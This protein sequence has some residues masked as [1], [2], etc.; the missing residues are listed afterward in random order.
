M[1]VI[2]PSDHIIEDGVH[3]LAEQVLVIV[4]QIERILIGR[5]RLLGMLLDLLNL[6]VLFLGAVAAVLGDARGEAVHALH[7]VDLL[8]ASPLQVS[9]EVGLQRERDV[10]AARELIVEGAASLLLGT[11]QLLAQMRHHPQ[12]LPQRLRRQLVGI[13]EGG[14]F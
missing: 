5:S 14:L 6:D 3:V 11:A 4:L 10:E 13:P 2:V 7:L 1:S 8:A 9:V 12:L